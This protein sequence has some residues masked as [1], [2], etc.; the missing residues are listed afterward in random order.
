MNL[1][2]NIQLV[3]LIFVSNHQMILSRY[4]ISK[5]LF[6]VIFGAQN[7]VIYAN[8]IDGWILKI[9]FP[10]SEN[11]NEINMYIMPIHCPTRFGHLTGRIP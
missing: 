4:L 10:D 5:C 7:L 6:L 8:N 9:N 3:K 1:P 2:T 11:P